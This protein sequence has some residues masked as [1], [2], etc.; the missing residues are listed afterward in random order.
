VAFFKAVASL[1]FAALA[2]N[3]TNNKPHGIV[4]QKTANVLTIANPQCYS[5]EAHGTK[6]GCSVRGINSLGDTLNGIDA[7]RGVLAADG[8]FH[9]HRTLF[10]PHLDC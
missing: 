5:T 7:K 8:I 2:L 1:L 4:T 6:R 10:A 3:K 9:V